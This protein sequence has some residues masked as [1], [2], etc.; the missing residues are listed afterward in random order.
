MVTPTDSR[1]VRIFL[2]STFRDFAEERDLLVRK[3][4]PELRRKCRE[5][6][7]ELVDVDLRWGITEKEAQQGKVLPICLAEVDRSRPWFMGFIGERY[8]WVPA[9]EQFDPAIVQ[10]QPW[11]EE[12]RGGKSVTELE[13]LHGVLNNPKMAGRAFFYF[14]DSKWSKKKG[15]SYLSEG[16][17]EKAKLEGLKERIRQSGFPVLE[18]YPSLEVL[19]ERVKEDLWRLIEEAFPESQVPDALMQERMRH[20]AFAS[21]RLGLYIGGEKYFPALDAAISAEPC[22]PVLVCGSS[23]GGKSALLANWCQTYSSAHPKAIL[24]TH[25]LGTGA[26]AAHPVNMAIRL[27][28]EISRTIGEELVLE[29]DPRRALRMLEGWLGKAGDF[30]RNNGSIFVLALD[31]L[32]KITE[33]RDLDWW[34]RRL[35]SGVA[36]IASCLDGEIRDAVLP[37]MGW[38]ELRVPPLERADCERFIRDHLAKYRKSLTP[39]QTELVLG[40]PISGNPLFLRTLLEELRVFGV[41]EEL[42]LRLKY[43]LASETIDDLFEKV[44]ERVESDNT[45]QF[46]RAVLEVL[47]AAKE[48]FAEDELLAVSGLP[49]AL[50]APIHIALDDSIIGTGGRLAFSHDYLRKAVE[51]RYLKSLEDQYRVQK[52]MADFCAQ[53]MKG[54]RK[55]TSRYVR[56]HAVEHFLD[57]EE[58]DAAAGALSDLEFI[59]ARAIPQELAA[60]LLDYTEADHGFPEAKEKNRIMQVLRDE[61]TRYGQATIEFASAWKRIRD[62]SMEAEP[63]LPEPPESVRLWDSEEIAREGQRLTGPPNRFDTV[64]AFQKFVATNLNALLDHAKQKGFTAQHA[65]N[66]AP[67]GPVHAAGAR[68]LEG[69]TH[70]KILRQF[71]QKETYNPLDPC[72]GGLEGHTGEVT[73]LVMTPDGNRVVSGSWDKTLWVWDIASGKCLRVLKG[74]TGWVSALAITPDGSRVVSGSR[75]RTLRVWDLASGECLRV[76]EGHGEEVYALAMTPDGRRVVSGSQDKTLR[77]WDIASGKRLRVLDAHTRGVK[78]LAMPPD[79][80]RVVS[81]SQDKTLRVWDIESGECLRVLEGHTGEVYALAMTPDGRRVVSGSRDRTLRVWDIESGECLRVLE[82][83]T[84]EVYS[85]AMTPDGRRFVSGSSDKTLR[86]WDIESGE[87]LRVLKGHTSFVSALAMTAGGHRVVS[88]SWDKTLRVWE[89]QYCEC[90]RVLEGHTGEVPALKMTLDGRRVVSGSQDKT[91]RVWDLA[92]GECLRMLEGHTHWVTALAI[93]PD[94]RRVVSGS[95]E[96]TLRIWDIDSGKCLHVLEA[97]TRGVKA[98]VM[99]PDGNRVVSGSWDKTL[100]VWDIAS[101]KCL[102]VLKGHTDWVSALAITPDGSR[103][104][105]GSRDRTL[106]VWDIAS[107]ECLRVFEGHANSVTTLAMTPDGSRVVSGSDDKTLRIWELES[108]KCLRVLEAHTR[109]VRAL[110]M[111]P[112]GCRIV[113]GSD[114]KTLRV[115]DFESGECLLTM[116]FNASVGAIS[117][118]LEHI[119][120]ANGSELFFAKHENLISGPIIATAQREELSDGLPAE[121]MTALPACCGQMLTIPEA[122]CVRIEHWANHYSVGAFTDPALMLDCPHCGTLLRMNPFFVNLK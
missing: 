122:V 58:W 27:L 77:V 39:E 10:E 33:H 93:T 63:A 112:D 47:W 30:A 69:K 17:E 12:H 99:T 2:S 53:A 4:F 78:A 41:H 103:V 80:R 109:G 7:V 57:V 34:P 81:G 11:L 98:L 37:K 66:S 121:L 42:N 114:D 100:W 75:D 94:G 68:L 26:D 113:S 24:L 61:A 90:L 97:H 14:R 102:R 43:Y 29:G 21:S 8:G 108:G 110:A 5:R 116:R 13:I 120:V 101:G 15:G 118:L 35:P 59:E 28:R 62:G 73:A 72:V 117:I 119:V 76:L 74:H 87:C 54:S 45:P 111:P 55:E 85:L 19:A 65:F 48:S 50:W 31:G 91:L 51:D 92:S 40:H 1:T 64:S 52:R 115:W 22:Q 23:G 38:S 89:L 79:G 96:K 106:R 60:V 86:V 105:S 70:I 32:D 88:G 44:L 95:F 9:A 71:H 6:Q 18:N 107:G 82:G 36:L 84:G 20:E 16:S 46:V 83:H 104:V 3:V 56:R 25:F 67:G 49:P